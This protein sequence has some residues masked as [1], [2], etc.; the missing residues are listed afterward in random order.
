ML[1]RDKLR[2]RLERQSARDDTRRRHWAARREE[3]IERGMEDPVL[4]AFCRICLTGMVAGSFM[5]ATGDLF[6]TPVWSA[7]LRNAAR[8]ALLAWLIFGAPLAAGCALQLRKGFD[9]PWFKR[10]G[11]TRKGRPRMPWGRKYRLW[12]AA[13]VVGALALGVLNLILCG[14][15]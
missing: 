12:L 3:R 14:A 10:H 15:A 13:A 1:N 4:P 6:H 8:S 9:H 2:A 11:L 7:A 5:A